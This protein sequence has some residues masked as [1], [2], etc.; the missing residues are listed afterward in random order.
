MMHTNGKPKQV[1]IKMKKRTRK[2]ARLFQNSSNE[3]DN[4]I[5]NL[6]NW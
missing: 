4:K 2:L 6:S 1:A 5:R 3:S